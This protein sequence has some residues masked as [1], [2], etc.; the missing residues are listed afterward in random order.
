LQQGDAKLMWNS[1]GRLMEL[2]DETLV[3][4]AHD[5]RGQ[6]ASTIGK[7]RRSNKRW[8]L[9]SEEA[10]VAEMA[11]LNMPLPKRIG[12]ALPFNQECR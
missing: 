2:P 5:Y 6:R 7:E 8:I 9:G 1:L 12:E 4:P 11:S 10:F 3:F